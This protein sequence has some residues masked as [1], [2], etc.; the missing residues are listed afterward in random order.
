MTSSLKLNAGI[1]VF[2]CAEGFV[3][4][5]IHHFFY[6]G[7]GFGRQPTEASKK[8]TEEYPASSVKNYTGFLCDKLIMG[9]TAGGI[10]RLAETAYYGKN[11]ANYLRFVTSVYQ[12]DIV[13]L[14][15][16]LVNAAL[17]NMPLARE[18]QQFITHAA[19][20]HTGTSYQSYADSQLPFAYFNRQVYSPSAR[21]NVSETEYYV[22][23]IYSNMLRL[24]VPLP[25]L[26]LSYT[27]SEQRMSKIDYSLHLMYRWQHP[28]PAQTLNE[29]NNN[30]RLSEK[31]PAFIFMAKLSEA[32]NPAYISETPNSAEIRQETVPLNFPELDLTAY[33]AEKPNAISLQLN[34]HKSPHYHADN[35]I[36]LTKSTDSLMPLKANNLETKLSSTQLSEQL[37]DSAYMVYSQE[38]AHANSEPQSKIISDIESRVK[39]GY[40][41]LEQNEAKAYNIADTSDETAVYFNKSNGTE[42]N[43]LTSGLSP[44]SPDKTIHLVGKKN[45]PELATNKDS[46]REDLCSAKPKIEE[47]KIGDKPLSYNE[48]RKREDLCAVVPESINQGKMYRLLLDE[49]SYDSSSRYIRVANK[50]GVSTEIAKSNSLLAGIDSLLERT[51][52]VAEYAKTKEGIYLKGIKGLEGVEYIIKVT[53]KFIGRERYLKRSIDKERF[54]PYTERIDIE[55]IKMR[56][57]RM[58]YSSIFNMNILSPIK[59]WMGEIVEGAAEAIRFKITEK[60]ARDISQGRYTLL[61]IVG[62]HLVQEGY[63]PV[64][65]SSDMLKD[66]KKIGKARHIEEVFFNGASVAKQ[67]KGMGI[68]VEYIDVMGQRSEPLA[69]DRVTALSLTKA[70]PM[71]GQ[72]IAVV[73]MLQGHYNRLDT[74]IPNEVMTL[75]KAA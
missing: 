41:A 38:I 69:N 64:Y 67:T 19:N 73:V 65:G 30:E 60:E 17:D 54:N 20:N 56:D 9:S 15:N 1:G 70:N 5:A 3:P 45:S 61:D 33:T 11:G 32:N 2:N 49:L 51:G 39:I 29:A 46:K 53:D 42:D 23:P 21:N 18:Q 26:V 47:I 24:M 10:G 22:Q 8:T 12:G 14:N 35:D 68:L 36:A 16:T 44:Y 74:Y 66:G 43:N 55:Y 48:L 40:S 4:L 62:N 63:S 72:E 71:A 31:S 28:M 50:E 59:N 34:N 52:L 57:S 13:A 25:Y 75:K 7:S 37:W 27:N 6:N 58:D